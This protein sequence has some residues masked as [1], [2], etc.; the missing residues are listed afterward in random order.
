MPFALLCT[1]NWC[2]QRKYAFNIWAYVLGSVRS[3]P[4]P[5]GLVPFGSVRYSPLT[6]GKGSVLMLLLRLM[7]LL[8]M[9]LLLL[10]I[11]LLLTMM[12]YG[13]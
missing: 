7:L 11:L 12:L 1:D 3:C 8:L 6:D 4:V 13:G 9:L 5:F 2:S 10:L